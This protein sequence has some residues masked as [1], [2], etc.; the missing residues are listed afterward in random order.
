MLIWKRDPAGWLESDL[1]PVTPRQI[2]D[3]PDEACPAD[4]VRHTGRRLLALT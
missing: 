4:R 1:S 2:E 3:S